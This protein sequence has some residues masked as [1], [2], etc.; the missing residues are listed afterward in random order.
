MAT[1]K[2]KN[3]TAKTVKIDEVPS[4]VAEVK[5]AK[6]KRKITIKDIS[7]NDLVEVVSTC[8]GR[9][10]Y[11]SKKTGYTVIWDEFGTSQYLTVDELMAMRNA[12]PAFFA[13]QW[14]QLSGDNSEDVISFLQLGK[15]YQNLIS[16]DEFESIFELDPDEIKSAIAKMSESMRE[17]VARRAFELIQAGELDSKKRIE[18]I[19]AATG[20]ELAE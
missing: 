7:L 14:V 20:F 8:Y 19:E 17:T 12:Y 2:T 18:A 15:Y 4:A 9:L 13:N 11:I 16:V 10:I 1:P 6:P 5:T 3:D